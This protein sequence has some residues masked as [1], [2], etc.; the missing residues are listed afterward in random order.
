[1]GELAKTLERMVNEILEYGTEDEMRILLCV[2][3]WGNCSVQQT[4]QRT[5]CRMARNCRSKDR[6]SRNEAD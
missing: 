6:D 4:A 3:N 5:I 2:T 1:M